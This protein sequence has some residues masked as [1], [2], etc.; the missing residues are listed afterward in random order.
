MSAMSEKRP[1]VK[2]RKRHNAIISLE[3]IYVCTVGCGL[4]ILSH[5][6]WTKAPSQDCASKDTDEEGFGTPL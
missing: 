5:F 2:C 6:H 4:A 1:F 3:V